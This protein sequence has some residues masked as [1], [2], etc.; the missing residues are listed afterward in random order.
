[1]LTR[2]LT[3]NAPSPCADSMAAPGPT[4]RVRQ[5][6][7]LA[8]RGFGSDTI[9]RVVSGSLDDDSAVDDDST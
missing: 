1:M 2:R 9:R 3:T 6:R 5:M 4:Q 7:F 8:A